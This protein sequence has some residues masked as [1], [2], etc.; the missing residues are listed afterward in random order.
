M[1]LAGLQLSVTYEW[2][3]SPELCEVKHNVFVEEEWDHSGHPD[4]VPGSVDEEKPG[5]ASELGDGVI[6]HT[7]SLV[8]VNLDMEEEIKWTNL[9][10]KVL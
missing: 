6:R 2:T 9:K 3:D 7:H 4:R 1:S 10:K 8:T 5:K